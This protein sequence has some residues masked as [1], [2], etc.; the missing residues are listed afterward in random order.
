MGNLQKLRIPSSLGIFS[1]DK[2]PAA[3]LTYGVSGQRFS[4]NAYRPSGCCFSF[5]LFILVLLF[6]PF[7]L[8]AEDEPPVIPIAKPSGDYYDAT[9]G[10]ADNFRKAFDTDVSFDIENYLEKVEDGHA[11]VT[12]SISG[13]EF[14]II[15]RNDMRDYKRELRNVFS[16]E[17]GS[18]VKHSDIYIYNKYKDIVVAKGDMNVSDLLVLKSIDGKSGTYIVNQEGSFEE[19]QAD[20]SKKQSTFFFLK[21][22]K[23]AHVFNNARLIKKKLHLMIGASYGF[24]FMSPFG[25]VVE[26][27]VKSTKA[28]PLYLSAGLV[29]MHRAG[30]MNGIGARLGMETF[31]SID[32][33]FGFQ[34]GLGFFA[35]SN[36]SVLYDIQSKSL[37]YV[38]DLEIGLKWFFDSEYAVSLGARFIDE[39]SKSPVGDLTSYSGKRSIC[40]SIGLLTIV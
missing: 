22:L 23:A 20:G 38:P 2:M 12:F 37:A 19:V 35:A 18:L 8:A 29:F 30:E 13:K 31:M 9:I 4:R 26:A 27:S 39:F 40:L 5:V 21:P 6:M 17:L 36:F 25:H 3:G 32:S 28:Y 34:T 33:F 16:A 14:K 10:E 11:I 15:S 24:Q 7:F 1:G